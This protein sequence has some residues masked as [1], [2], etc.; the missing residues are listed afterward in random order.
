MP[1]TVSHPHHPTGRLAARSDPIL[2]QGCLDGEKES[3]E[4]LVNRYGRLV[5]SVARRFGLAEADAQD[6]FQNVFVIVYRKLAGVRDRKR[7]A[8]W[9][10]R[11]TQ[12]E[13]YRLGA[14]VA[15]RAAG[16]QDLAHVEGPAQDQVAVWERRVLVRVAL[17]RLGGRCE[18]LLTALFLAPGCPNYETLAQEMGM[19]IGSIGPTRARCFQ[20][21]EQILKELGFKDQDSPKDVSRPS[22]LPSAR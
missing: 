7:L 21:L 6:V 9:L 11:T 4:E 18:Q 19:K 8:A 10:I 22:P 17:R 12:R 2:I 16:E 5:Y 20:K 14:R 1:A 15:A 3:W 13:C